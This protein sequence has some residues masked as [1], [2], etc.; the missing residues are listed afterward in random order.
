MVVSI[1]PDAVTQNSTTASSNA[2]ILV[3]G[4]LQGGL[5]VRSGGILYAYNNDGN[6]DKAESAGTVPIGGNP[7]VIEW[8]HEGGLIYQ[9]VNG[10]NETST[11]SGNTSDLTGS[12]RMGGNALTDRF[13]NGKVF[14]A[15]IYST[16]PTLAERN[17]IVNDMMIWVGA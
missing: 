13:F 2:N 7:C 10:A 16:V 11:A 5:T 6:Q 14:E 1:R 3:F 17:A 9:R 4:G 12:L 15:M 8:R